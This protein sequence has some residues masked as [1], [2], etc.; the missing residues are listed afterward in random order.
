MTMDP[1]ITAL[2][3]ELNV[4]IDDVDVGAILDLARDAAHN[5]ERPAAPVS[6]FIAGY[7][8]ALRGGGSGAVATTLDTA[9]ELATN[10][11]GHGPQA[12][13]TSDATPPLDGGG[14]PSAD[15]DATTPSDRT[16]P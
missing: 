10:W 8:A 16:E 15:A 5:V 4:P 3:E 11:P 1:W 2:C 13:A 12:A 7:A 14:Q 9:A 6:T